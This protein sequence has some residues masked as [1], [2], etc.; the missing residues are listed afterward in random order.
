MG[1]P[2]FSEE[3]FVILKVYADEYTRRQKGKQT[4]PEFVAFG[5]YIGTQEDWLKFSSIGSLS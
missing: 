3:I 4:G 5:G 1:L 2:F